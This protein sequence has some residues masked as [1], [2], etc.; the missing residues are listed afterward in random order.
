MRVKISQMLT[1]Q[2][3]SSDLPGQRLPSAGY[4]TSDTRGRCRCSTWLQWPVSSSQQTANSKYNLD[5]VRATY[6]RL[7]AVTKEEADAI[8]I[9]LDCHDSNRTIHRAV[10]HGGVTCDLSATH[11]HKTTN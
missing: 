3:A 11:P 7:R 4:E 6:K 5:T 9:L 10:E 2:A 1:A 8:F